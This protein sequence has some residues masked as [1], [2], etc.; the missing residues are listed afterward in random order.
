MIHRSSRSCEAKLTERERI[1]T[2][3]GG[4]LFEGRYKALLFDMDG[5]VLNSIAAAER[6][7]RAWATD[8]GLDVESFLPT[9]HGAR[10][11]DTIVALQLPGIN[12]EIEAQGIA[13]AEIASVDGIV[14]IAGAA[15]FL[16]SL[17]VNRWAIVTSAP[18]ALA[19][20][21]LKAAGLPFPP[22]L[23]TS[24]DVTIGKPDP[25]GYELAAQKLGVNVKECL[26]FEDSAVG[27]LAAEAAGAQ[28]IVVAEA[29]IH[30]V[31]PARTTIPAYEELIAHVDDEGFIH[32]SA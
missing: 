2:A 20:A 17:P 8:H 6:V 9:I 23:V 10:T 26:I 4:S 24:E 14:E 18:L 28:V 27:I 19:T 32:V 31:E 15:K 22:V 29:H 1:V 30:P 3:K 7:W 12:P 5:T 16:R 25:E 11:V 21:R 13:E